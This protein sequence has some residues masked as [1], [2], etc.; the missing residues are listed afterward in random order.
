MRGRLSLV[1]AAGTCG[2]EA[3]VSASGI[4]LDEAP[5]SVAFAVLS[6]RQAERVVIKAA[7]IARDAV[8]RM[9]TH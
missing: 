2:A 7:R 6:V 1:V 3:G 4:G 5:C 9:S 8:L